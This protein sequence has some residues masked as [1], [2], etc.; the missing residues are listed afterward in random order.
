MEVCASLGG[1]RFADAHADPVEG[2]PGLLPTLLCD[3]LTA[4]A[5]AQAVCPAPLS[6]HRNGEGQKIELSMLDAAIAF[7]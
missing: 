4:L 6:R 2:Q 5:A 3:K 7:L 1:I